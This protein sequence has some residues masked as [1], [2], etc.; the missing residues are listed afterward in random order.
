M[1]N[2]CNQVYQ[3]CEKYEQVEFFHVGRNNP[4]LKKCDNLCNEKLDAQGF[5]N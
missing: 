4:Y 3:F 5:K 2:L 1:S